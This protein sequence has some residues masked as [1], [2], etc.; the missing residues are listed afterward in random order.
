MEDNV[1]K[2]PKF[3]KNKPTTATKSVKR[4]K[5]RINLKSFKLWIT[6]M[7]LAGLGSL[8]TGG[9]IWYTNIFTDQDR[10]FYGMIAKSLE[11][12]SVSRTVNENQSGRFETQ[13]FL[14]S[15][16]PTPLVMSESSVEQVN[17]N[18]DK[19]TVETETV[20][21]SEGDYIRYTDIKIA[22]SE[23]D[24]TD[25]SKVLGTWAKRASSPEKGQPAQFLNEAIFT[26]VPFGNFPQDKRTELLNL[27]QEKKVYKYSKGSVSYENGRP[28]Y[29]MTASISP[30]G[31][32]HVL[33][34]YNEFT[35]LGDSSQLNPDQYDED[36]VFSMDIRI[37]MIS[38]H[39]LEIVYPGESRTETFTA[40]G[41]NRQIDVP[42]RT[43]SVEEL[44]SRLKQ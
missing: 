31:L 21:T 32:I 2:L 7:V 4:G 39:L 22:E 44:Q 41:L 33:K 16:S 34:K 12:E 3:R 25:Y 24:K 11:V 8:G 5:L 38:R 14:T 37:D 23:N 28:V 43:I 6:I 42:E 29:N 17:Q 1:K 13:H 30:R 20:G 27:I 10:I 18:R 19:S 40:Y 35:K 36:Y 9:Y 26:F 15:F